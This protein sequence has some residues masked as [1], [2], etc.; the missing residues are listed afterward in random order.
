MFEG[1]EVLTL[2]DKCY[3]LGIYIVANIREGCVRFIILQDRPLHGREHVI[4]LQSGVTK[5]VKQPVHIILFLA[6]KLDT[7]H[8]TLNLK[9]LLPPVTKRS[10][11]RQD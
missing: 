8:H 9:L 1:V 6:H 7:I 10:F 11:R 2:L 4:E 3:I 5:Q